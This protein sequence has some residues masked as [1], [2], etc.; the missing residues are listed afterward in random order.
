IRACPRRAILGNARRMILL[1]TKSC[2]IQQEGFS[3]RIFDRFIG[4][5]WMVLG[6]T[7]MLGVPVQAQR[8]SYTFTK[9]ATLGDPA[10]GGGF[11]INDFEPGAIDNCGDVIYG[12]DVADST[13]SGEGVFVQRG[14]QESGLFRDSLLL[15]QSVLN[16]QGDAV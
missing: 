5:P 1:R 13:F 2:V 11:H 15:G 7:A 4:S 9:L 10:P 3:M 12:T 14:F 16:D 8:G 6:L